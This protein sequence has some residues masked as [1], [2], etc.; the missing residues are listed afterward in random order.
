MSRESKSIDKK[1]LYFSMSDSELVHQVCRRERLT[2]FNFIKTHLC[3][4]GRSN[5]TKL[6]SSA[7]ATTLNEERIK[8][9]I[10]SEYQHY[11]KRKAALNIY[12]DRLL[13]LEGIVNDLKQKI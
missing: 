8:D 12:A 3:D 10:H 6:E 2:L 11:F 13:N 1:A 4:Q 5:L 7:I 9:L